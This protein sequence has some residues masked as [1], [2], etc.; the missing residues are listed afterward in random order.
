[1]IES[2]SDE[3]DGIEYKIAFEKDGPCVPVSESFGFP[4]DK[5]LIDSSNSK[6]SNSSNDLTVKKRSLEETRIFRDSKTSK[7]ST[8]LLSTDSL[9]PNLISNE[10]TGPCPKIV[11]KAHDSRDF[12]ISE[13]SKPETRI[14]RNPSV[15]FDYSVDKQGNGK[16]KPWLKQVLCKFFVN[17]ICRAGE[18]CNFGHDLSLSNKRTKSTELMIEN[19]NRLTDSLDK[20]DTLENATVKHSEQSI[21]IFRDPKTL[22][23]S[24]GNAEICPEPATRISP[25]ANILTKGGAYSQLPTRPK[26]FLHTSSYIFFLKR[27]V[28]LFS[29]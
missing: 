16:S 7:L 18:K 24:S 25:N 19:V 8:R 21:R 27:Y 10:V 14:A 15:P 29:H 22:Q 17:G 26:H 2:E 5:T 11:E 4:C 13:Q 20:I 6:T 1:M 12:R 28:S 9:I 3:D 23:L